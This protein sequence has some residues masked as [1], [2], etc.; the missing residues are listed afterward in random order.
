VLE[1]QTHP[2]EAERLAILAR[3]GVLDT[4]A[5]PEFDG[6]VELAAAIADMP[7]ALISL[8]D[9][10][11]QWFKA[12]HGLDATETPRPVAFC[13]HAILTPD[14][15]LVVEDALSDPRFADNPLVCGGPRVVFYAGV[16][17]RVGPDRL[18]VGTLCVIDSRARTLDASRLRQLQQLARQAELLLDLRLRSRQLE[19]RLVVVRR[20][21]ERLQALLAAMDEGIVEQRADGVI[22]SCNPAAERI[23]GLSADQLMGRSSLDPSWRAVH[24]DGRPFPGD[25]H[26]AMVAMRSGRPVRGVVMGVGTGEGDQRWILINAQPVSLLPDGRAGSVVT[27]FSDITALHRAKEQAEAAGHAKSEFLAT[28]SHEIRTPMNGVIGLT[29]VLLGTRLDEQQREMLVSVQDSG[30]ALLAILNDI[31]DWSRIEAGRLELEVAPV[32]ARRVVRDVVT[33]LSPQAQGKGLDLRVEV[34]GDAPPGVLADAGRLRQVLFNLVGNAVKFT[35]SGNVVVGIHR[36]AS[37]RIAFAVTDTGIGIAPEQQARLFQR[38]SQVDASATRRF[39]GSGLGLAISRHLAQAMGGDISLHSTLGQGSTFTVELP[40]AT[41]EEMRASA[42]TRSSGEI[43]AVTVVPLRLL[44]AEDN[45][46]NQR[47]VLALLARDG[48]QVELAANG[49]EAVA[50]FRRAR[51]DAVIMDVQMPEMDGLEATRAIRALEPIGEARIPIIALTASAMSDERIAC[52]IAG[53]DQ[54]VSKPVIGA[55]LRAALAAIR[56]A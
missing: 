15:P 36:T 55:A 1:P 8:V 13:A 39:G 11:R 47:V 12:R 18:P 52:T 23:L 42:E 29:D 34:A 28:M 48:H 17:L 3:C 33:V 9:A 20:D 41:E 35:L 50:A 25:Q 45:P 24:P 46:V 27:S 56:P 54:V 5:E 49:I 51:F 22:V 53:M 37:G 32:E 43:A 31:L 21:E 30:R 38:F 2:R 19:D 14:Q 7:V 6:L 40:A 16:P 26:P 10:Q 4:P 44:V